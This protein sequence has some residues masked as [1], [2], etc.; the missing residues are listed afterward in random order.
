MKI[1]LVVSNRDRFDLST[2]PSKFFIKSLENQ[3]FK[4]F[5]VL[6]VDGGSNNYEQIKEQIKDIS[7]M[8]SMQYRI[9]EEFERAKLNNVGILNSDSKYILTTDVDMFFGQDFIQNVIDELDK[10]DCFVESRTLYWK[11]CTSKPLYNGKI[12]ILD[13]EKLRS[14][15]RIKKRTSAGGCQ[16]T[17]ID[18]W[19]KVRG[20]DEKFIGWGSE[21]YDLLRRIHKL[22]IPVKWI[23]EN[24]D[25]IQLFHQ[26]HLKENIENDLKCQN[27][28]KKILN[29]E[30]N[31]YDINPLGW[32]GKINKEIY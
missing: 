11:K 26:P 10:E 20:F 25:S 4:D 31:I 12:D 28:N 13:L 24:R 22:N 7:F 8:Q 21:D 3:S 32:G 2:N 17:S 14:H 6:L 29:S 23:G 9:G 5:S 15:G 1:T 27:E 16:C 19:K 18:N 30:R